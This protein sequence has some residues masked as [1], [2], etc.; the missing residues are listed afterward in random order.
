MMSVPIKFQQGQRIYLRPLE[1]T[2][3]DS[4]YQITNN[5]TEGRRL[6]GTQNF[7][8]KSQI[9]NYIINQ[10]QDQSRVTFAIVRQEDDLFIGEVVVNGISWINRSGNLRI[11]ISDAY[12]NKGYGSE[13]IQ[14]MLAHVFGTLNLNRI[15]LDVYA[16]NERAA[17]V[18]EK[19]GFK[20]EGIRRQD[21]F[22]NHKYY[23]SIIMS[24]LQEEYKEIQEMK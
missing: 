20:Q 11:M 4:L 23:D 7:F 22:Y 6:T 18:Y 3:A 10:S 16:F 13:A 1:T 9:E 14:L 5:D 12:V 8:T 24:I 15:E 2:D 17:H 21:L 19:F